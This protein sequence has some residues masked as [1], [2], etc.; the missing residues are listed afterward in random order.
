M[1]SGLRDIDMSDLKYSIWDRGPS[2]LVIPI[3]G[4]HECSK[5]YTQYL[6]T[7]SAQHPVT[8]G[9][10][11]CRQQ[12]LRLPPPGAGVRSRPNL[13]CAVFQSHR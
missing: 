4:K 13:L 10:W 6:W 5:Q 11:V 2:I 9:A 3:E 8:C 1:V 7:E 12:V